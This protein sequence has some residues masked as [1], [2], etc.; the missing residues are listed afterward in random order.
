MNDLKTGVTKDSSKVQSR[1]CIFFY[2]SLIRIVATVTPALTMGH[3]SWGILIKDT[4][5]SVY[6]DLPE[7]TAKKVTEL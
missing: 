6:L 7:K 1:F 3:A 4:V 5:V 2:F